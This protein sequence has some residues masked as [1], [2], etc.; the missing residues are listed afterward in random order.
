MSAR[1]WWLF[2][3]LGLIWGIPYLLIRVAV[4]DLPP[5]CVAF[6]RTLIGALLLLPIAAMRGE[7]RPLLRYWK[8]LLAFT[9]VEI[10]IP[11]WL[12]GYAETRINS[13]TAGLLI[14]LVPV[15]TAGLMALSGRE[16]LNGR[17]SLGLAVGLGGVVAL[18]GLDIDV[19]NGWA[20]GAALATA[21]GYALGPIVISRYLSGVP[22]LG[23]I[24]ASLAVAAALYI[25]FAIPA[26]PPQVTMKA[27]GSVLVLGVFCTAIAFL[28]F[29]SLIAE[30]GPTRATVITYVNPVVALLL[31]VWLLHEPLT[32]GMLVG[33]ALVLLGSFLATSRGASQHGAE[34]V[35]IG[36]DES[37]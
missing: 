6:A 17:R 23:V 24:A 36:S 35:P 28:L 10:S 37:R 20:V 14:A 34:P 29:F 32:P 26:W 25:P 7:L 18:V 16:V 21:L 30:A 4:A 5:V 2:L 8:P 3:A 12:L 31:G 1:A 33:F 13:S 19:S 27:A 22:P 11:W 9:L 15:L